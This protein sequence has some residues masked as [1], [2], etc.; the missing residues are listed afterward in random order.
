MRVPV[1]YLVVALL[2]SGCFMQDMSPTERLRDAVIE[3]NDHA[4]WHR[5]DTA[6]QL[7]AANYQPTYQYTHT[8][9]GH[10]IQIADTEIKQVIINKKKDLA[11]SIVVVKWYDQQ[12]MRVTQTELLQEWQKSG[13]TFLLIN[14]TIQSGQK[15][16]L[17][18]QPTTPV[19]E[20]EDNWDYPPGY[21]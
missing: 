7:V 12:S 11:Q 9:W 5:I 8:N 13:R 15:S 18:E 4:R 21:K 1:S 2:C 16:L 6:S 3:L 17:A 14:E 19:P 10:R 20:E